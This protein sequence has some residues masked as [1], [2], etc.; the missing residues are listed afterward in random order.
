[1]GAGRQEILFDKPFL[2]LT[3]DARFEYLHAQWRGNITFAEVH[4]GA[5]KV[6]EVIRT[7]R[8]QRLLN[9]N[10]A[11]YQMSL[12]P[13]E[14]RSYQI[15]DLLFEGGLHY[16]AWVYA[17]VPEGRAYA[18]NSIAVTGWPLILTFE[19]V[20]PASEWLRQVTRQH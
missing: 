8:Y 7:G 11:V 6:L 14:Q 2:L 19:E 17:P 3:Y 10:T 1:M 20:G 5:E 9:D 18:E 12:T 15:M 13:E 16:L 4:E